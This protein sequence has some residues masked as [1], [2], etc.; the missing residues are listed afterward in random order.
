MMYK[1]PIRASGNAVQ[2]NSAH[3]VLNTIKRNLITGLLAVQMMLL[4]GITAT[5]HA[6][7]VVD[8]RVT[9]IPGILPSPFLSEFESNF[10]TGIYQV[11]MNVMN[12]PA[13]IVFRVEMVKDGRVVAEEFSRPMSYE[14]GIYFL[15]PFF[16]MV[17]FDRSEED[18]FADLESR[19]RNQV[20]QSGALPEGEYRITIEAQAAPG[21]PP[22]IPVTVPAPFS[23][24][25]PQPPILFTPPD[26]GTVAIT[27]PIFTWSPVLAPGGTVL[28]Y[29]FLLVE[30]FDGQNPGD[31]ILSNREH[32]R[33]TVSNLTI[34]VYTGEFLPLEKGKTYAWQV[35][36][37]DQNNVLPVKNEGRSEIYTF[38]FND[39]S[40]ISET[41]DQLQSITLYPG[42]AVLTNLDELEVTDSGPY[43]VLNGPATV[44]FNFGDLQQK[45]EAS[46]VVQNLTIQKTGLGNPVIT[47]G[48]VDITTRGLNDALF[49]E[50]NLVQ[51]SQVRYEFGTGITA[52]AR[53][54]TEAFGSVEAEGTLQLTPSGFE[55][56]L[57]ATG[58]DILAF[59]GNH[60]EVIINALTITLPGEYIT[61]DA[62]LN[63]LGHQTPCSLYDLDIRG[64]E[65]RS[66]WNCQE[67]ASDT[68]GGDP[69]KVQ[70][71][72]TNIAG[73]FTAGMADRSLTYELDLAGTVHFGFANTAPCGIRLGMQLTDSTEPEFTTFGNTC[74][75]PD[76]Y[77][78]LGFARIV[79]TDIGTDRLTYNN[80]EWD[81]QFSFYPRVD[82]PVFN[83]WSYSPAEKVV[84]NRTGIVI[85]AF[86]LPET[87]STTTTTTTTFTRT[88][89][90][91]SPFTDSDDADFKR[92]LD[93]LT[94]LPTY[95]H[96]GFMV[97]L[98]EFLLDGFTFPWY[99][100]DGSGSGPWP[101]SFRARAGFD[102]SGNLPECLRTTVF[103]IDGRIT[104]S[105]ILQANAK[106]GSDTRCEI[107]LGPAHHLNVSDLAAQLEARFT[108]REPELQGTLQMKAEL[109]ADS[110]FSCG[111]TPVFDT[112][113][114]S[115]GIRDGFLQGEVRGIRSRC[116]VAI[117]PFTASFAEMSLR[118]ND[119]DGLQGA[120]V[121]AS[122][123]I[124]I[125]GT[126]VNGS[127][128]YD[129]ARQ[130]FIAVSFD[131]NRPFDLAIPEDKPAF[132]FR[133]NR[134]RLDEKGFFVDGRNQVLV[135]DES[136]GVTFDEMLIDLN[137]RRITSGSV[138]FDSHFGFTVATG[139]EDSPLEFTAVPAGYTP[140]PTDLLH[141][142]LGGTVVID[143]Q[144]L[145]TSGEAAAS[146]NLGDRSYTDAT[147]EFSDDFAM[148]LF[149]LAINAGSATINWV[150]TSVAI[151]DAEGIRPLYAGLAS[152]F[153]PAR[154]PLPSLQVAWLQLRDDEGELLVGI[155]ELS[156]NLVRLQTLPG[157]PLEIY[158]PVLD[159]LAPPVLA[160]VNLEDVVVSPIPGNFSVVSGIISVDIPEDGSVFDHEALG[161]P[162][163]PRRV[164][165]GVADEIES[166]VLNIAGDLSMFGREFGEQA[167]SV[168]RIFSDGSLMGEFD[169]EGLD[170]P[171]PL[172]EQ[173]DKI[174]L[175]IDRVTGVISSPNVTQSYPHFDFT[176]GGRFRINA[177]SP[178]AAVSE[179]ELRMA[180]GIFS[181]ESLQP[182]VLDEPI[183]LNLGQFE[184]N[185]NAITSIP[186]LGYHPEQGWEFAIDMDVDA[187]FHLSG[188]DY[189]RIP[190]Q[191]IM[192]SNTGFSIPLQDFNTANTGIELPALELEGFVLKP[193]AIRTD[194][195]I[196][197]NWVTGELPQFNPS[198]DF[199]LQLPALEH[200]GLVPPDGLTFANVTLSNGYLNGQMLPW[201]PLGGLPVTIGTD[202]I[203]A[204]ILRVESIAGS[205]SPPAIPGER[206]PVSVNMSGS[207]DDIPPFS[208]RQA[209]C[210]I[211]GNWDFEIAEGRGFNGSITELNPC[212]EIEFGPFHLG[213]PVAS[214]TMAY[215]DGR[216]S[217][218]LSGTATVELTP[219][220]P[221]NPPIQA[222]GNLTVDLMTGTVTAGE[223]AINQP[224]LLTLPARADSPLLSFTVNS[225]VL[226]RD[227]LR[228]DAAGTLAL[229]ATSAN[230]NFNNLLLG[231]P[232]FD[233]VE[234]SA[235]IQGGFALQLGLNPLELAIIDPSSALPQGNVIRFATTADILLTSDGLQY[236]GTGTAQLRFN[237][238]LHGPLRV[239]FHDGFSMN[240]RTAAV[241]RGR[242]EFYLD[243]AGP[244]EDPIAI[245]DV[246]GLRLGAGLLAFIPDRLGLPSED[247]AYVQIRNESGDLLVSATEVQGGGTLFSTGDN[248]LPVVFPALSYGSASV[249]EVGVRFAIET[250]DAF[251]PRSGSMSLATNLDLEPWLNI[252]VR[253]DSLGVDRENGLTVRLLAGLPA[254]FGNHT[255]RGTATVNQNGITA[256]M[257]EAGNYRSSWSGSA[258]LMYEHTLSGQLGNDSEALTL[259]VYGAEIH[260][261]GSRGIRVS[262][263]IRS[264]L[265]QH[266]GQMLPLFYNAEYMNGNW[267]GEAG[268]PL[269]AAISVGMAS[270]IINDHDG[271]SL[272][273]AGDRF[274]VGFNGRVSFGDFLGEDLEFAFNNLQVGVENLPG[275]PSLLFRLDAASA[276]FETQ[277]FNF[278]DGRLTGTI[279]EPSLTIQGKRLTASSSTGSLSFMNRGF[280]YQNLT[281]DNQGNFNIGSIS[282]GTMNIIGNYLVLKSLA[283]SAGSDTGLD[284]SAAFN[285][286]IPD[287]VDVTGEAILR[288]RRNAN[289][290]IAV[291]TES[292]GLQLNN[293]I[294][295]GSNFEFVLTGFLLD[296]DP[297]VITQTGIYATGKVLYK[298]SERIQ[299]GSAP[300]IRN[301]PGIAVRA[302]AATPV[303]YNV[304]GNTGFKVVTDFIF[305]DVNAGLA[306]SDSSN[307][308]IMLDGMAG[309]T[310]PG[311]SGTAGFSGLTV[312]RT[313]IVQLGN[314]TGEATFSL[315]E[316]ASL[317]V[318]AFHY[319]QSE[320]G[321]DVSMKSGSGSDPASV[322]DQPIR[323]KELLCFGPCPAIPGSNSDVALRLSLGGS[324]E[325]ENA[326]FSGGVDRVMF[327][328]TMDGDLAFYIDNLNMSVSGDIS[329]QA[330][331][332]FESGNSGYL[333]RAA[334][335][336]NILGTSALVAGKIA[337]I[338]NELSFGFFVAIGSST[339]IP[340]APGITLTGAGAGFFYRPDDDDIQMVVD[341][342]AAK[343]FEYERVKPGP[344]SLPQNSKFALM[345]FAQVDLAGAGGASALS[346]TTFVLVSGGYFDMDVR[347]HFLNMDGS[348]SIGA[349]LSAAMNVTFRADPFLLAT[350]FEINVKV[351][352]QGE[353]IDGEGGINFVYTEVDGSKVFVLKGF[354]NIDI[355]N[356]LKGNIE[357][358]ASNKGFFVTGGISLDFLNNDYINISANLE[359][360]VWYIPSET[361][362][363]FGAYGTATLTITFGI[364]VRPELRAIFIKR[365]PGFDLFANARSCVNL[366][367]TTK[368]LGI[369]VLVQHND[370]DWGW[371][372]GDFARY[373]DEA[374][375][376]KKRFEDDINATIAAVNAAKEALEQPSPPVMPTFTPE[377]I[378]EAGMYLY[379]L[380]N[381]SRGLWANK[382]RNNETLTNASSQRI[383]S[384]L[385][386][387]LEVPKPQ[388]SFVYD[389]ITMENS[390]NEAVGLLDG[391]INR[392]REANI[393]SVEILNES[394]ELMSSVISSFE[395][396][397]IKGFSKGS[398]TGQITEPTFNIDTE[399]AGQQGANADAL[400][401]ELQRLEAQYLQA[402]ATMEENV[403]EINSMLGASYSLSFNFL[404]SNQLQIQNEFPGFGTATATFTLPVNAVSEIFT[405]ALSSIDTYYAGEA[406]LLARNVQWAIN[407][408]NWINQ[409]NTFLTAE[410]DTNTNRTRFAFE[411][412][413]TSRGDYINAY[414]ERLNITYRLLNRQNASYTSYQ[415]SSA[416][417]D[418]RN[419]YND[420]QNL[421]STNSSI[422]ASTLS[423]IQSFHRQ[424]W[425]P[426][427]RD[428]L[429]QYRI[430]LIGGEET[431]MAS[432]LTRHAEQRGALIQAHMETTR[433]I[434]RF[435]QNK[436]AIYTNLYNMID[437]FVELKLG[438]N[439]DDPIL[440]NYMQRRSEITDI[441]QPPVLTGLQVSGGYTAGY[442][443]NNATVNWDVTHPSGIAE[444]SIMVREQSVQNF[445]KEMTGYFSV[446]NRNSIDYTT[447]KHR[448]GTVT[449]PLSGA[450]L[451]TNQVSFSVRA[452]GTG[453]LTSFRT[454]LFDLK[455]GAAGTQTS[456]TTQ[457]LTSGTASD[458]FAPSIIQSTFYEPRMEGSTKTGYWSSDEN[459]IRI[460]IRARSNVGDIQRVEYAISETR[461]GTPIMDWAQLVASREQFPSSTPTY[462]YKGISRL[463]NL[464]PG[465]PYFIRAR[466]FD[467]QGNSRLVYGA[468]PVILDSTPPSDPTE[469]QLL[470]AV[471]YS[472]PPQTTVNEMIN[473]TPQSESNWFAVIYN[474]PKVSMSWA[475]S[476]DPE[477]GILHYEYALTSGNTATNADFLTGNT[478]TTTMVT[479]SGDDQRFSQLLN[480]TS[481][482]YMHVRAVNRA[483]SRSEIYTVGPVT[484]RDPTIPWM[485]HMRGR[486]TSN[487]VRA[488]IVRT[489][490]DPET[491]V[492]GYQF[493]VGTS[494]GASDAR[495]WSSVIT[496]ANLRVVDNGAP[497]HYF[498]HSALPEGVHLYINT[499]SVNNQDMSSN[500]ISAGPFLLD[501]TPPVIGSLVF[502]EYNGYLQARLRQTND[503]ESGINRVR[504]RLLNLLGTEVKGWQTVYTGNWPAGSNLDRNINVDLTGTSLTAFQVIVQ[505]EVRNGLNL[506]ST[507]S[508]G[509]HAPF[510]SFQ[511]P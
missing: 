458:L 240:I 54:Q 69:A 196:T 423:E 95:S 297:A 108:G 6:Q 112:A 410:A 434:D 363:P 128:T 315:M 449:N 324:S 412:R 14:P 117:G 370:W 494:P 437:N 94:F 393:R 490:L 372:E 329:M 416:H 402:I 301:N 429:Y 351:S 119:A 141:F 27:T 336:A 312:D 47:G 241:T 40:L 62:R 260:L 337:N 110:P 200:Y 80:G 322:E 472:E 26:R 409:N 121:S 373:L 55:G 41:L 376:L 157:Q 168:I 291:T 374:E 23:V 491:G 369:Y 385:T 509:Y 246:N 68:F 52:G 79:V 327:Y 21:S 10:R 9:G 34:L 163:K 65:I 84:I 226:N 238:E 198:F 109:L 93:G 155:T 167:Q 381:Y 445:M 475:A 29:E 338:G 118:F 111:T 137:T 249:P 510:S 77:I 98:T 365:N 132:T 303:R 64:E 215:G 243:T 467:S 191:G 205:L 92:L 212:G 462:D 310:L 252:P 257:I 293:K 392:L 508:S 51:L 248:Y 5:L 30:V 105:G 436:A 399:L 296:I 492:K 73:N 432:V 150:G 185:I 67:V 125:G 463:F 473:Y 178:A 352:G 299:F 153:L 361:S 503:P 476:Q 461:L 104:D 353:I 354:V 484:P 219:P 450:A 101:F 435:Y 258:P 383:R 186:V 371:G 140:V 500:I 227:G 45:V 222:S 362:M 481:P 160:G 443:K 438:T 43:Y 446:G 182:V 427:H 341:A 194:G 44:E 135:G 487:S 230:V 209:G 12:G 284:L 120:E 380:D 485:P 367:I 273:M 433:Y 31:A 453:G 269:N 100:W 478:A 189:F 448:F 276:V 493:S 253:V 139:G 398:T 387:V 350:D 192:L 506:I 3:A 317:K 298:D 195:A 70:I 225:A 149:P 431:P 89:R 247:I 460:H 279:G 197:F 465:K 405:T 164:L 379:S 406:D 419:A 302:G 288:I 181:V 239:E 425:T 78:D 13:D 330:S 144:G 468:I 126:S 4:T 348:G 255:V 495:S 35:T 499:R 343:P 455:V 278:F 102:K 359:A 277:T 286:T 202:V 384:L 234:G 113:T 321:F 261:A 294:E 377:Q 138:Y 270:L 466:V 282:S 309:L 201:T 470:Q 415:F 203:D 172:T 421:A 355:L 251:V 199:E 11:Q 511:L 404:G 424:Y 142:N 59:R 498:M 20:L 430:R 479:F 216:Q 124:S 422:P 504:Y 116:E 426:I 250:D 344:I 174:R 413:W 18:I 244:A 60:I 218:L 378:S 72:I 505:V 127:F 46:A 208:R 292:P 454:A 497:Y 184:F 388:Y 214:L 99:R 229:G 440:E 390:V 75:I 360:G 221:Q 400:Y 232:S 382:I 306:K 457:L 496:P 254:A 304:T 193:L 33:E 451:N 264:S 396:S 274:M 245:L 49:D 358:L 408:A 213:Y 395:E 308:R 474:I 22:I 166:M 364:T 263:T 231:L 335:S 316:I 295:L 368:C 134:A 85:P 159:P 444:V 156:D 122:A 488:H 19:L 357:L 145:R 190:L 211:T 235:A 146:L 86:R 339:G 36:A 148:S 97:S 1:K 452:R 319:R 152:G 259:G 480:Y 313:G 151:I 469:P 176:I 346:G 162:F 464:E 334:G 37:S 502:S 290:T 414:A 28:D 129:L 507:K 325:S 188:G 439:P 24:R 328:R 441:L 366:L 287:P 486:L 477:S 90:L 2:I 407:G 171:V 482:V 236:T 114:H 220:N 103:D 345:L 206:Q 228:T 300:N 280:T 74:T 82:V 204:L 471:L 272:T 283:M 123:T 88:T 8:V 418:V 501:S 66:G 389:L 489:G 289:N 420:L 131:L 187:G 177:A 256:A 136:I 170:V 459:F 333:L 307:F 375:A 50:F 332:H 266:Q 224:F 42:I 217:A 411:R 161:L 16:S 281:A 483:G 143:S 165:Y 223:I 107:P 265:L 179:I 340:L 91:D 25:Y 391:V 183:P 130:R 268:N 207:I 233:V 158:L 210:T 331:L 76:P 133:I 115:L 173:F 32:A 58:R 349:V 81:F 456:S 242:A 347:G 7:P 342:L 63:V 356:R 147:I 285:Y 83:N 326:A 57:R 61:A 311:I 96:D 48:R 314:F 271:L 15:S 428:G 154:L 275:N 442:F 320:T 53:V 169:L 305:V 394:K 386:N 17:R 267:Q 39:D 237:D 323:L 175:E 397:P 403:T 417:T 87:T 318:G 38:V 447:Y 262:G 401:A 71:D 56:T 180:P 106:T